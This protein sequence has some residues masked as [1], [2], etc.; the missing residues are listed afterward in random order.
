MMKTE[1]A[2]V[3]LMVYDYIIDHVL[4]TL[5]RR[6]HKKSRYQIR[7]RVSVKLREKINDQVLEQ[8]YDPI[9]RNG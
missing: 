5:R 2:S 7:S 3:E 6:V 9:G 1:L 8:T 4:G